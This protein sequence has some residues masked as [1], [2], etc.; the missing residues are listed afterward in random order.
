MYIVSVTAT[1]DLQYFIQHGNS[2]DAKFCVSTG[3]NRIFVIHI[4][5]LQQLKLHGEVAH[6]R[7]FPCDAHAV[8]DFVAAVIDVLQRDGNHV[9]VVVG[10]N[11][12]RNA[13]AQ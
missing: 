7:G 8:R 11:T 13:Q 5:W 4:L 3:H 12:A 9:D 1:I 6:E 10:V 2:R